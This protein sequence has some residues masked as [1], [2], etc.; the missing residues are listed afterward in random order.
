[1][2]TTTRRA[3]S[4]Q[5]PRLVHLARKL[6]QRRDGHEVDD[7]ADGNRAPALR[8][9]S[10][11]SE[12]FGIWARG[13]RPHG[14]ALR[15]HRRSPRP[16]H[17][18]PLD[19]ALRARLPPSPSTSGR[20]QSSPAET[21]YKPP[22]AATNSAATF[23]ADSAARTV[24]WICCHDHPAVRR[25]PPRRS[26]V[27]YA[28]ATSCGVIPTTTSSRASAAGGWRCSTSSPKWCSPSTS[29]TALG[30]CFRAWASL[31]PATTTGGGHWQS[32]SRLAILIG[33]CAIVFAVQTDIV[34]SAKRLFG[35]ES[36]PGPRRQG[37]RR[38]PPREVGPPSFRPEAGQPVQSAQVRRHRRRDRARRRRPPPR[39]SPRWA[40]T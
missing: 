33:N 35:A 16:A 2:T 32:C 30:A 18:P 26:H 9:H 14:E 37:P 15:R 23:A 1:M 21:G 20:P 10:P 19:P 17:P 38:P 7:G 39:P 36:A 22:G 25:L 5:A 6:L 31:A 29:T 24:R 27:D 12:V 8:G 3:D 28:T 11:C 34:W 40:T 4:E 13:D